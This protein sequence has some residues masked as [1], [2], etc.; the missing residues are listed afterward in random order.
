M[1]GWPAV[2]LST[3]HYLGALTFAG[4]TV[5]EVAIARDP[6]PGPLRTVLAASGRGPGVPPDPGWTLRVVRRFSSW[7]L[8][9]V[10]V[11]AGTGLAVAAARVGGAEGL[12]GTPY[13]RLL[14]VKVLLVGL[15]VV[16]AAVNRNRV[17]PAILCRA[18]GPDGWSRLRRLV[19]YEVGVLVAVVVVTGVLTHEP[20]GPVGGP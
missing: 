14:V 9:S 2:V 6:T 18:E 16:L 15:V 4:A 10:A 7:A 3:L 19:A 17:V 8:G 12:V 13:G 20:G 5:F 1:T 11:V